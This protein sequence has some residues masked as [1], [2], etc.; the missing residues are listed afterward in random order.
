MLGISSTLQPRPPPLAR[1]V[2]KNDQ[3]ALQLMAQKG[4]REPY[5]C[6][7]RAPAAGSVPELSEN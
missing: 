3:P 6:Q 7:Q 4:L 1:V 2:G 5:R